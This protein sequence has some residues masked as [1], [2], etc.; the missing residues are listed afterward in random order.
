M[1]APIE[2]S[3]SINF[4]NLSTEQLKVQEHQIITMNEELEKGRQEYLKQIQETL[5]SIENQNPVLKAYGSF[6]QMSRVESMLETIG[7]PKYKEQ[8]DNINKLSKKL[9]PNYEPPKQTEEQI[10]LFQ[11]FEGFSLHYLQI[12]ASINKNKQT[13]ECIRTTLTERNISNNV[14]I[15]SPGFFTDLFKIYNLPDRTQASIEK[16]LRN[17]AFKGNVEDLKQFIKLTTNVNARDNN[18]N[19]GKTALDWV[20]SK[21]QDKNNPKHKDYLEC[22]QILTEA[23]A[24]NSNQSPA[25]NY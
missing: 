7:S 23:G 14:S 13:L 11:L 24:V 22:L 19:S 17:A 1:Y 18:P 10:Q 8:L 3:D 15:N 16:G 21:C 25:P 9:L 5:L 4:K 6:A 2:L 20:Q 12:I